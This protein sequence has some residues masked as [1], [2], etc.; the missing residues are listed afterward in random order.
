[1]IEHKNCINPDGSPPSRSLVTYFTCCLV[2]NSSTINET[3]E[4][5]NGHCTCRIFRFHFFHIWRSLS[6]EDLVE[7]DT[8]KILLWSYDIHRNTLIMLSSCNSSNIGTV[9]IWL[10]HMVAIIHDGINRY[11]QKHRRSA[12]LISREIII[13]KRNNNGFHQLAF[14]IKVTVKDVE[15]M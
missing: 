2:Q 6:W 9:T 12:G 8:M 3:R 13:N 15:E 1:M 5:G 11:H 7:D 14:I 10:E 4:N